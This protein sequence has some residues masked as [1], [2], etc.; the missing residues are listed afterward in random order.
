MVLAIDFD[1]TVVV[2]EGR[3]YEDVTT[4]LQFMPYAK[5]ALT[6]LKQAGHVLLLYSARA[7]RALLED[8]EYDPLVRAGKRKVDAEAW[9]RSQ[10]INLQRY[11]QMVEFV[12]RE[13]PGIF[14]AVDDGR[15]GKPCVDLFIDD[16]AVKFGFGATAFSWPWIARMY[17]E[18]GKS[19]SA[20]PRPM[21]KGA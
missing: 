17:G 21:Q 13:L 4:P 15:Q 10:K 12:H 16:R 3:S 9:R 18:P 19:H 6:A 14:D 7:N 5:Q 11:K 1:A 20:D 8:P 2:Q